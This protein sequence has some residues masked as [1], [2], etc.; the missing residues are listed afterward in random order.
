MIFLN[1]CCDNA[2]RK[3]WNK[4]YVLLKSSFK[5]ATSVDKNPDI[6][7]WQNPNKVKLCIIKR[8]YK[9]S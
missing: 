9:I 8:K 2:N 3:E 7:T 4:V 5:R 1:L 6:Y